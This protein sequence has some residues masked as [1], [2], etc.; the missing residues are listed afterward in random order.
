MSV[1]WTWQRL[2]M[3]RTNQSEWQILTILPRVVDLVLSERHRRELQNGRFVGPDNYH[4]S[5][6]LL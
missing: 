1:S 6:V 2:H 5:W 4:F 3:H